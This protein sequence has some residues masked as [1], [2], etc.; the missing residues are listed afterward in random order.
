MS[1]PRRARN[2]HPLLLAVRR[3]PFLMFG[4]P[5]VTLIV[6]AS[7]GLQGLTQTRYDLHQQRSSTMSKEEELGMDKSRKR[8]DI[9]EEYF[10]SLPSGRRAQRGITICE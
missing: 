3:R 7:F 5:F 10:V 8:L 9:R 2:P 1:L 6:L 4:A